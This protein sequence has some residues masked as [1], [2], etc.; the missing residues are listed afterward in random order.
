[1]QYA[2]YQLHL[3]RRQIHDINT[4]GWE[5]APP[6]FMDIKAG[7]AKPEQYREAFPEYSHVCDIDAFSLNDV[8]EVGN[9]GPVERIHQTETPMSSISVG[10]LIHAVETDRWYAVAPVGFEHIEGLSLLKRNST[11][12]PQAHDFTDSTEIEDA[13]KD[14][15]SPSGQKPSP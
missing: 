14:A 7:Y 13:L 8:F 4:D 5:K 9:I 3:S 2:V 1:M 12:N 11:N 10:D 15:P 6:N